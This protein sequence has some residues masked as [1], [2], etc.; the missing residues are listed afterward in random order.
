M[1][2]QR[3]RRLVRAVMAGA[4]IL[5]LAGCTPLFVGGTAAGASVIDD[6]RSMGAVVNDT[7]IKLR[8]EAI[9]SADKNLRHDTHVD[10]TSVNG[11]VLLTGE[12]GN[13]T[14]RD[15]ILTIIRNIS[16]VQKIINQ[17]R[18]A[19]PS[20][21]ASRLADSWI[22]LRVKSALVA[23]GL[24]ANRIKV[25]TAHRVVYLLGLVP[26]AQGNEAALVA[27]RIPQVRSIIELFEYRP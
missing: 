21:F 13:T 25:V 8:A 22:T 2:R 6:R 4:T 7:F 11:L 10:I 24:D 23:H 3:A 1:Q 26:A 14:E 5:G 15:K 19:P 12:A 18:L 27:S 20:S 9:I 17:L 16:G